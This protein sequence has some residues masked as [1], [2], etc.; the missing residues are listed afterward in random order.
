MK[1]TTKTKGNAPSDSQLD[2]LELEDKFPLLVFLVVLERLVV[3]PADRLLAL[4]A[5]DVAHNVT[6]RGHAT[7]RG[8]TGFDIDDRVEQVSLTMLA[9]E[10]LHHAASVTEA[11]PTRDIA[12]IGYANKER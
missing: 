5:G 9:A 3:L 11:W 6:P 10:V 8:L 7:L 2:P 4:A 1:P 12:W